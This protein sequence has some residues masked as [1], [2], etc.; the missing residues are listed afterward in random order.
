M[1]PRRF[2]IAAWLFLVTLAGSLPAADTAAPYD[3]QQRLD[4]L[5]PGLTAE[6]QAARRVP[7][8]QWQEFCF[9][10]SQSGREA[11]RTAACRVMAEKLVPSTPAPARIWLL[12]QLQLIG[13][14]E[15]V[16]AVAAQLDDADPLVFDAARRAL[17]EIPVPEAGA[18]LRERMQNAPD[19]AKKAALIAALGD[20][21]EEAS[22]PVLGDRL[23]DADAQVA[24]AAAK[25][26]GRIGTPAAA[27][28]LANARRQAA[29]TLRLQIG[30]ACLRC[31]DR[32]LAAGQTAEAAAIYRELNVPG[33]PA[34]LAALKGVLQTAG[35]RAA[36]IVLDVL[37]E[38]DPAAHRVAVQH[39]HEL[40]GNAI[41]DLAI[42]WTKLPAEGQV[43]LLGALGTGGDPAGLP[44]VLAAVDSDNADVRIAAIRALGGVGNAAS[45]PRLIEIMQTGGDAG[46][47]A[48]GSIEAVWAEGAD[49]A[50]VN[51]MKRTE[52]PGQRAVLIEI[53]ERRRA[54]AAVSAL[55]QEILHDDANVRRR[56]MSALGQ[57]AG[58][59]D[60][61]G[62]LTGL[63]RSSE[64]G[65]RDEA[66]KA[67]AAV[68]ARIPDDA[69]Q[70]DVVVAVYQRSPDEQRAIILPVLGRIGSARALQTVR[71]AI[72]SSDPR[73]HDSGVRAI[74]NWPDSAVA[75]DLLKLAESTADGANR[76]RALRAL[77]RVA[78]LPSDRSEAS[79]LQ[80]LEHG[81]RLAAR[82]EERNLI[83][84]RAREARTV[85]SARFAA[86]FLDHP[87]LAERASRT[88]VEVA[89]RREIR[90]P[91]QHRGSRCF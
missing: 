33:E 14:A 90:E 19:A 55:L 28:R 30:D 54:V 47:A 86:R 10:L 75:E 80:L 77:A 37:A 12:K 61:A 79:K 56:A 32:L 41:R 74:C 58:A 65:E 85:E 22:V 3:P 42:G 24:E 8:Q 48:R 38:D 36:A 29:G 20:R 45:L 67:I 46:Q 51:A 21:A 49:E 34:R 43:R 72:T 26:L 63:I 23:S 11:D 18:K 39:V 1:K 64:G 27:T 60:V 53:L 31:A 6:D 84:D 89:H 44:A 50:L 40:S 62:M 71:A 69:Q 13:G 15:C 83:L 88:I 2:L 82:D 7:E 4:E 70:V 73:E 9:P 87:A 17:A 59:D 16:A 81:M 5:W 91:N 57:L 52:D 66:E 35:D 68:C 78:V 76:I 25:A